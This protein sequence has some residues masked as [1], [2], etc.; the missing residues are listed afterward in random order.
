MAEPVEEQKRTVRGPARWAPILASGLLLVPLFVHLVCL[1]S[2]GRLQS[3]DYYGVL[4]RLSDGHQLTS[5]LGTWL[6]IRIVYHRVAVPALIWALNIEVFHGSNT[7]TAALA[8]GFLAGVFLILYRHLPER[9]G[10]RSPERW[11]VA[12]TISVLVFAPQAVYNLALSFGGIHYYLSDLLAVLSIAVV[13]HFAGSRLGPWPLV[14]L[15]LVVSFTFSSH[16]AL[17]PALVIG[18]LVLSRRRRDLAVVVLAAGIAY[19]FFLWGIHPFSRP[20]SSWPGA[21]PILRYLG[22]FLGAPFT[23]EAEVARTLGWIGLGLSAV[24]QLWVHVRLPAARPAAAFW[25]MVQLYGLGNGLVAALARVAKFGEAQAMAARYQLFVGLFWAG[26]AVA[27]ALVIRH[28]APR[29]RLLAIVAGGLALTAAAVSVYV[30]GART[31]TDFAHRG[32]RQE[33]AELG[34]LW[35]SWDEDLIRQT[36][37]RNP[38]RPIGMTELLRRLGHVP[39][40]RAVPEMSHQRVP[41]ELLSPRPHPEIEGDWSEVRSTSNGDLLRVRGWA[42]HPLRATE[43]VVFVDRARRRKSRI[44][45]G[46]H[47]AELLGRPAVGWEGFVEWR[48]R[49]DVWTPYVRLASDPNFYPLP[50]SLAAERQLGRILAQ[51]LGPAAEGARQE[52]PLR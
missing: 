6:N 33:V 44:L 9:L 15:S 35:S 43:E 48:R 21:E 2:L 12:A 1:P 11:L 4:D 13:V 7:T 47:R 52:R 14:F 37:S 29:R 51:R 38:A 20:A 18:T 49:R 5:E 46:L 41:R 19:G 40:D 36:V 50:R 24:L 39:F 42:H 3:N 34:F 28:A 23:R 31:L 25:L 26:A 30:K 10:H 8:L 16:L 27:A 22:I 17:W 32:Q 45:L